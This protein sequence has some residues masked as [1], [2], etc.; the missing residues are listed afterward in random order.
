MLLQDLRY[1]V[2]MLAK[3]PTFTVV[4]LVSLAFGI[5][6][7]TLVFS[8]VNTIFLRP[9]M[10]DDPDTLVNILGPRV[11]FADHLALRERLDPQLE[12][13]AFRRTGGMVDTGS[14][15]VPTHM[16]LV[17]DNYFAALAL[18]PSLGRLSGAGEALGPN[19]AGCVISE[20]LWRERL[21]AD[22]RVVGRTLRLSDKA[23]A[24]V[25]VAPRGFRGPE[26]FWDID[27][28]LL[29]DRQRHGGPN[30]T[31]DWAQVG[32][33]RAG[34]SIAQ[35]R[36]AVQR[37]FREV[38]VVDP[39]TGRSRT[40][41][42]SL[43]DVLRVR[44][45]PVVVFTSLAV[46]VLLV[47]CANVAGLL[48]AR[49]EE[50]RSEMAIR[51]S[52]GSGRA[53]LVRQLLTETLLLCASGAALGLLLT[54]LLAAVAMR[55][56]PFAT[57]E[58]RWDARV[59]ALAVLLTGLAALA[60][61]LLPAL[62]ATRGDL[63]PTLK[64]AS[65][66]APGGRHRITPRKL[67]VVGQLCISFAFLATAGLFLQ[68]L[69]R[70]TGDI[71]LPLD[72]LLAVDTAVTI[73]DAHGARLVQRDVLER[74]RAI[75]G[76]VDATLA[77]GLPLMRGPSREV[78]CAGGAP[79]GSETHGL[80]SVQWA[81]PNYFAMA[82]LRLRRGRLYSDE[83]DRQGAGVVVVSETMAQ[84]FWPSVDP[85]GRTVRIGGPTAAAREIIGIVEDP[86]LLSQAGAARPVP[87]LFVPHGADES[88][89]ATILIGTRGPAFAL[90]EAVRSA[91]L[92]ERGRVASSQIRTLA[93]IVQ[94]ELSAQRIGVIFLV[95]L[96]LLASA[97]ATVGLHA[98]LTHVIALRTHEIGIR[99]AIGA[100][101]ADAV[102]L[103]VRQGL[104]LACVGAGLG[105]PLAFLAAHIA[106]SG[107][108][109][110]PPLNVAILAGSALV[111]F[112][113]AAIASYLPAR[114]AAQV[115]PVVALRCE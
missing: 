108:F 34:V 69:H 45:A 52:L 80:A 97:L 49:S 9:Q 112:V 90:A 47:A 83:E 20:D 3:S 19:D 103:I 36:S 93:Q 48:A 53:R 8:V 105:L 70:Y 72:R 27:L 101:R 61:G 59:L 33:L 75:P 94:L 86:P 87:F 25:G 104:V 114:R 29:A 85:V 15:P 60:A 10:V 23:L 71:A 37:A 79:G 99:M 31:R 63:T 6:I 65:A 106:Q 73:P 30:E 22:P 58:V 96:G 62:R 54:R 7:T 91:L 76:V 18:K 28:W 109:D 78:Y 1:A 44:Y 98:T 95:T 102:G 55:Q 2:R 100:R 4:A 115:D 16:H 89:A 84:R 46:L 12:L 111:I 67:L 107:H 51:L 32:R 17:S 57:L 41:L 81:Q 82:A 56:I 113:T 26:L 92:T 11:S 77:A 110:V 43:A 24:V 64:G 14:G 13:A 50:R 66:P 88:R 5:G 74:L 68:A 40:G 39:Q 21:G 38:G 42:Q 35:A